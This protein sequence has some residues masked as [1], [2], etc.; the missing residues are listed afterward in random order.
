MYRNVNIH[1]RSSKIQVTSSSSKESNLYISKIGSLS[2]TIY[3]P[4]SSWKKA[5]ENG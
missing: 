3:S 2:T 5:M 4:L 1:P